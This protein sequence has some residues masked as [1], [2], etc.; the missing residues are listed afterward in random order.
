[1]TLKHQ[2]GAKAR[3]DKPP[4]SGYYPL[5]SFCGKQQRYE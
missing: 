1:M 4:A 2:L 5:H 3:E